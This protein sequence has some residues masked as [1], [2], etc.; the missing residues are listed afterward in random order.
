MMLHGLASID[1]QAKKQNKSMLIILFPDP[2]ILRRIVANRLVLVGSFPTQRPAPNPGGVTVHGGF[3]MFVIS[4][5]FS[6]CND[7][8]NLLLTWPVIHHHICLSNNNPKSFRLKTRMA[9]QK[10]SKQKMILK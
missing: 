6:L 3:H 10:K 4:S 9:K 1:K 8:L 2:S 5:I 7:A